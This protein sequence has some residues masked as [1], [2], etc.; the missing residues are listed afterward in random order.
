MLAFVL[1]GLLTAVNTEMAVPAAGQQVQSA[2]W[3]GGTPRPPSDTFELRSPGRK[4]W[5]QLHQLWSSLI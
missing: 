1:K 3:D 5:L 4:S 2:H